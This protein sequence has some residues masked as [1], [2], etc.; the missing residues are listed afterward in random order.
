MAFCSTLAA[1]VP[2]FT[3]DSKRMPGNWHGKAAPSKYGAAQP[4][5]GYF[6][7]FLLFISPPPC[8]FSGE[9]CPFE[10]KVRE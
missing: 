6:F 2:A 7:F 10:E 4:S 5:S 3:T 8:Y 1:P 9:A